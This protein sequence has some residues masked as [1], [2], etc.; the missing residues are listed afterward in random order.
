M[1]QFNDEKKSE[2]ESVISEDMNNSSIYLSNYDSNGVFFLKRVEKYLNLPEKEFIPIEYTHFNGIKIPGDIYHINKLGEIK[3]IKTGKILKGTIRKDNSYCQVCLRINSRDVIIL[4]HRLVASTFLINPNPDL[5]KVVNHID[6][7]PKNNNL[8][9]LEWVTQAENTN[10][11]RGKSL[12]IPKEKLVQYVALDDSGNEVFRI[13]RRNKKEYSVES[14]YYAIKN[15]IKYKGFYWKVENKKERIIPGFSGNLE[16]YEWLE[17]WKYSGLY[18]CKEGFVKYRDRI[19]YSISNGYVVSGIRVNNN[20]IYFKIHR[21]IMEY[22]LGRDLRSD[23]IVDH[24][25]TIRTDNSFSNLRVTDAKGNMN[26]S[27]TIEKISRKI[28]LANLLGDFINYN[29]LKL[30]YKYIFGKNLDNSTNCKTLINSD[31]VGKRYICIELEDKETLY[32]KMERVI[33]VF[34]KDKTEVLG[35][36]DS[37]IGAS[38][39]FQ[40]SRQIIITGINSGEL[41]SDGNYYLR[42]PEAVKLVLSLGHGTAGDYKPEE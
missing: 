8:S 37:A 10:K 13:T 20:R 2:V 38:R 30:N 33:Y 36:F 26:N 29:T 21:L 5:Y 41:T 42:G 9:N 3:N 6:H 4:I 1:R 24:I 39:Q 17:H 25:N 28:V 11:E 12:S 34:N 27:I 40:S 18:V 22:I 7:N 31:I 23:E 19:L 16:D 14:M 15:D 35:A 32:K